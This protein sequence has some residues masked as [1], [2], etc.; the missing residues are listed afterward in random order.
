MTTEKVLAGDNEG[1]NDSAMTSCE[2]QVTGHG[3]SCVLN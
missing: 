3:Q 1:T 2:L